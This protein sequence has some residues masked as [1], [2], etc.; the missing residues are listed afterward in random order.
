M[1]F[2]VKNYIYQNLYEFAE[3]PSI[4]LSKYYFVLIYSY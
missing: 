3:I 1:M 2:E 4:N